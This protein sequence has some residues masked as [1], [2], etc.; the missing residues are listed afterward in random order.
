MVLAVPVL[1]VALTMARPGP[2]PSPTL[3]PSFDGP[4]AAALTREFSSQHARRVPGT[5][6]AVK[7]ASWFRDK[8]E[9]Y[10]LSVETDGWT[11]AVPGLGQVKL[12]NLAVVIPGAF[13]ET[14]VVVAHR[15]N[16]VQTTGANDN[17]SGTAALIELARGYATVGTGGAEPRQPLHTVVL[18]STDAGAYGGEGVERFSQ[19]SRFRQRLTAALVL[20]GL[21]GDA[22]P[23]IEVAGLDRT[24]PTPALVRTLA[25]R[26]TGETG[27]SPERP[28]F[29]RQLVSLGLPFGAGEQAPLLRGGI[30]AVRL[31]TSPDGEAVPG[32]DEVA[33]LDDTALTQLGTAVDATL[34][35]LDAAVELPRSTAGTVFLGGR[36]V[37]GWALELLYLAA[38][39]PFA[40]AA[41]DLAGR[42]R[43]RQLRLLPGWLALRRLLGWWLAVAAAV[44]AATLLGAFPGA[45]D[46]PPTPA[47]PAL[48]RWSAVAVTLVALVAVAAWLRSRTARVRR[49]EP[50]A[51]EVLAGWGATLLALGAVALVTALAS[52]YTLVFVL[53]SLYAWLL[54]PHVPTTKGW[55]PDVLFGLG[56]AGPIVAMVTVAHQLD[57]GLRAPLYAISLCTTGTVPWLATL[58]L[59]GW[60]AV[61][62]QVATLVSGTYSPGGQPQRRR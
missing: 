28:S 43:R 19:T 50:S 27:R 1:V 24:S 37:R 34:N 26:V 4:T 22:A 8:I 30:P 31:S 46:L 42:C 32:S 60:A 45:Q 5:P 12:E 25:A 52:P 35:S 11:E 61:A 33:K 23:R 20:D 16:T 18:L 53:P 56:L 47:D 55:L 29:V 51:D 41:F 57:L 14:I 48:D 40:A 38:L 17:A 49:R 2:L 54:V 9:Q 39:A 58:A 21:A 15:D 7:A 13:D 62:T 6:D 44:A 10:G 36:A 3:P 59:I